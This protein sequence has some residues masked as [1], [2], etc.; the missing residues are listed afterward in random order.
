MKMSI[1]GT[2]VLVVC[3]GATAALADTA[4]I[5]FGGFGGGGFNYTQG[6]YLAGF[7]FRV[8]A[9]ISVTQLGFYDASS[10]GQPQTFEN[11][12]VGLWDITTNTLLGSVIVT[13]ADPLTGFFRYTAL[14]TPIALNTTDTYAVAGITGTNYYTAGVPPNSS[15]VVVN[16]P[17]VYLAPALESS[18]QSTTLHEPDSFPTDYGYFADFGSNFQF[19]TASNTCTY[20]LSA[21]GQEFPASGGSGS[22]SVTAGAGCAWTVTGNPTWIT[23]ASGSTGSGNGTVNFAVSPNAGGPLTATLTIAGQTFTVDEAAAVGTSPVPVINAIVNGATFKAGTNP[24]AANSFVSIFG[25]KFGSANTNGNIFP[26]TSFQGLSVLVNG[27]AIPLYVVSG[28]GGQINVVLPSELG[29]PGSANVEV[30][31]A[32]GSSVPFQLALTAD[33]VGIFRVADPSDPK[34]MNG[35][36]LFTNTAWKVMPLSMAAALGLPSCASVTTASICG[37]PAQVGDQIEIYLTGLG[38]AT[39]NGDPNGAVLPTGLLAPTNGSVLYKTVEMPVVTIGGV[40]A[41]VE[42][43]GIAPGNAGQYQINVQVPPGVQSGDNVTLQVTMPDGSTD[44]VTIA[45]TS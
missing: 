3:V 20:S 18:G 35:A 21:A 7:E 15:S 43:S 38:K 42:F 31:T 6:S 22:I 4:A 17:V 25:Q 41:L 26:A 36:V 45:I 12:P 34:R 29:A 27:T 13:A 44:T 8:Q 40:P 33:S 11:A 23:I 9:A 10:N 16:S 2:F 39:P 24:Q 32:E 5:S 30:M 28:T 14:S 37:K 1:A 19:T